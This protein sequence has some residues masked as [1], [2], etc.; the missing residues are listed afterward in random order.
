MAYRFIDKYKEF[1]GL[2]WL[3]RR[4]D[5]YPN[6][7]YTYRKNRRAS[8]HRKKQEIF[9]QIKRIYYNNN[10]IL[11]H[12]PMK[13]FL[14]RKGVAL[15]K[16]TVHKYMN[17]E[18][19]LHAVIM[20]KKPS[21]VRG[22]KNKIFPNLLRQKFQ[23]KAPNL[24]WCTDFTYIRLSNGKMRYNCTVMDLYDRSVVSSLNSEHINTELAKAALEKAIEG[25]KPGKGLILH[26]DQGSQYSSWEFVDYCKKRGIRQSMSKAGCPYDNAPMERFYNTFKNELIY[27]NSF[28]SAESLDE[29]VRRYVYVWYNHVRPHSYNGWKTPFEARYRT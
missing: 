22:V 19:D 12:R 26:S 10:R 7:Y 17:R 1:F 14:E 13:I 18:L 11:G 4:L 20:R 16:T 6:A 28:S 9:H 21:Y 24:V 5:I 25:E 23:V 2:R 8:Y 3:L 15:S 29:A 27:P